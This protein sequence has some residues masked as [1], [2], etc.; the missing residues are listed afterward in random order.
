MLVLSRK[1]GEVITI[2]SD[3]KITVL[4]IDRGLVRLGIDA[5]KEISVH[6]QE[7][8]DNTSDISRKS[9]EPDD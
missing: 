2:G 6:R 4:G 3:I 7:I 9:A 1:V 8:L 5:P